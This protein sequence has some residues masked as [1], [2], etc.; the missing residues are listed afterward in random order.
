MFLAI[1][2]ESY[3]VFN[4]QCF[5]IYNQLPRQHNIFYHRALTDFPAWEVGLVHWPNT[6]V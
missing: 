4:Y 5:M 2:T 6:S 1:E 3:E